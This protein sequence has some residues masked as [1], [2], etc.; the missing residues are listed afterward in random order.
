MSAD[1]TTIFEGYRALLEDAISQDA[2][3]EDVE[4]E[5]DR[6]ALDGEE[7]AALWLWATSQ[8]EGTGSPGTAR[9]VIGAPARPGWTTARHPAYEG[10]ID[11]EFD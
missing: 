7:K 1:A 2:A 4:Q 10:E 6:F 8:R 3:I 9:T 5:I 11:E